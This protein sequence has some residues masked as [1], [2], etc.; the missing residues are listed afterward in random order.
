MAM[1]RGDSPKASRVGVAW[2][3]REDWARL[4]EISAD[5]E[6]LEATFEAWE[7]VAIA[8]MAELRSHG[9][10]VS[11]VPVDLDRLASWCRGQDI[12]VDARSRARFAAEELE[13]ERTDLERGGGAGRGPA[14]GEHR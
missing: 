14:G 12:P 4:I 13:L 8:T 1:K 3:R 6:D 10:D 11:R 5:R 9:V 2:F 7:A